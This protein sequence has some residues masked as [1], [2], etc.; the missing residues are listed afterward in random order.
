MNQ[1]SF[2]GQWVGTWNSPSAG[3]N[4]TADLAIDADGRVAGTLHDNVA[5]NDAVLSGS[6][7]REG[8]LAAEA[9]YP[10]QVTCSLRGPMMLNQPGHTSGCHQ[11]GHMVGNLSL[12]MGSG[13][14]ETALDLAPR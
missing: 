10:D 5:N 13:D 4:G 2:R 12:H 7:T 1:P 8:E 14:H 3:A 6:I 9:R 11:L